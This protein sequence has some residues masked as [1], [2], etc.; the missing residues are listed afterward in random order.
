MRRSLKAVRA[1]V[2]RLGAAAGQPSSEEIDE[3]FIALLQSARH[4]KPVERAV[5]TV[6]EMI[7][8]G[9]ELRARLTA[10]GLL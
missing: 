3:A 7:A 2:E 4:E 5:L 1:R 9:R 8:E 6:E 10:A